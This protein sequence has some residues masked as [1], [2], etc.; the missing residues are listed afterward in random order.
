M[1]SVS[2]EDLLNIPLAILNSSSVIHQEIYLAEL[3]KM[4]DPNISYFP[5]TRT[6]IEL[7]NNDC[8]ATVAIKRPFNRH[9]RTC[10]YLPIKNIEMLQLVAIYPVNF[11][12]EKKKQLSEVWGIFF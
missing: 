6:I 4:G 5:G 7:L 12:A 2:L 8:I 1:H 11:D 9:D 3:F 10:K